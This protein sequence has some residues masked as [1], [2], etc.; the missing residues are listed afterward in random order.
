M[1]LKLITQLKSGEL[2][3]MLLYRAGLKLGYYRAVT[4]EPPASISSLEMDGLWV[5]KIQACAKKFKT[6]DIHPP[7]KEADEICQG[8]FRLFGGEPIVL[9][10]DPGTN[11][12]HWTSYEL[13]KAKPPVE[14][15]KFLW[16]PARMGWA[17]VL[18]RAYSL[19]GDSKYSRT[20]WELVGKFL[21]T[22][23]PYLGPNW[24][25]A[26]EAAIRI[27]SL[28]FALPLFW[29]AFESTP[30]RKQGIIES[31]AFHAF[32]IMPTLA[33]ARAQNNNHL[34][35]E[36][37]GLFTAGTIL[38]N[39]PNS[40]IWKRRGWQIINHCLQTQIEP[41]GEYC[42]HSVNYHRLMLQ[43]GLWVDF[44]CRFSSTVLPEKSLSR[45]QEATLWLAALVDPETG[46]AP[47][48]GHN[49]GSL[50]LPLA[51][52]DYSN[53]FPT[54]STA[55]R[56]FLGEETKQVDEMTL[57][58][59]LD[60]QPVIHGKPAE[61]S[62]IPSI[63][64]GR[65]KGFLRSH[66]YSNRPAHA[67]QLHVD[68]WR[69]GKPITLDPGTYQYNAASP[70]DN[71]LARTIVHNT[72]T[73]DGKDQMT[74]FSRF[75]WL[76]WAKSALIEK[77]KD[78]ITAGHLGYEKLGCIHR[79]TLECESENHWT[80]IDQVI[81]Q[82]KHKTSRQVILNW[83]FPDGD[84]KFDKESSSFQLDKMSCAVSG[85]N[86][87]DFELQSSY[88]IIRAGQV[89][90]GE[91][92]VSPLLG[93]FSPTHGVKIPCLSFRLIAITSATISLKT[94]FQFTK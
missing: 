41:G 69:D 87:K 80:V 74:R 17:I 24:T 33:Y 14:D 55:K 49:D 94:D 84:W 50:L 52:I 63:S 53:Y 75:L 62:S 9:N 13:G 32:R 43:A 78:K 35:L 11:L 25:S 59:D 16:E 86:E 82:K 76:D 27:I 37:T 29:N 66:C 47:N 91:G 38:P 5:E 79:R 73:I 67:D 42:Q 89:I 23:P 93:W 58:L 65:T 72:V 70:W 77:S 54:L 40:Q 31:L 64:I 2:I 90:L 36:G 48:L 57:W 20:F 51:S 46:N 34:L 12:S 39:H 8:K 28:S 92:E 83:N 1:Y 22:N 71:G 61:S 44:L 4:Q 3:N 45:L 26:Q 15:I 18:A 60:S 6:A 56:A 7:I 30:T 81:F 85:R 10:L 19:T 88:Q 68:I 21:K